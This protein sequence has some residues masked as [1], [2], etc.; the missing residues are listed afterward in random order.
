M[1][2]GLYTSL[3]ELLL[4]NELPMDL[5]VRFVAVDLIEHIERLGN[6]C[7]KREHKHC[8]A[9]IVETAVPQQMMT[10]RQSFHRLTLDRQLKIRKN[11][12]LKINEM[13][14]NILGKRN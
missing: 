5:A 14:K 12:E 3:V 13:C 2:R 10:F 11:L 8:F 7:K 6:K 1:A 9:C 4:T